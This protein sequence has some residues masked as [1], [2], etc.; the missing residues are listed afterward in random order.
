LNHTLIRTALFSTMGVFKKLWQRIT[1][2]RPTRKKQPGEAGALPPTTDYSLVENGVTG[3]P[4]APAHRHTDNI[5]ATHVART[6]PSSTMPATTATSTPATTQQA[7]ATDK[8][9]ASHYTLDAEQGQSCVSEITMSFFTLRDDEYSEANDYSEC[10]ESVGANYVSTRSPT[11][12]TLFSYQSPP[13]T[14]SSNSPNKPSVEGSVATSEFS[15]S[16]VTPLPHQDTLR[17]IDEHAVV[18][19]QASDSQRRTNQH[20]EGEPIRNLEDHNRGKDPPASQRFVAGN[21]ALPPRQPVRTYREESLID[22]DPSLSP[23]EAV[24]AAAKNTV[25]PVSCNRTNHKHHQGQKAKIR[26]VPRNTEMNE[27]S[28]LSV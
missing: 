10:T 22:M 13:T 28:V 7:Q 16:T 6:A 3:K 4:V 26:H 12:T 19:A 2:D 21:S 15:E 9:E 8:K 27:I 17:T 25:S 11:S 5:L 24:E 1:K 14:K 23:P 20:M 18:N